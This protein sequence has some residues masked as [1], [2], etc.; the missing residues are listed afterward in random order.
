MYILADGKKHF[1]LADEKYQQSKKNL[2]DETIIFTDK[3]ESLQKEFESLK[4]G[5]LMLSENLELK[6]L[7]PFFGFQ[8]HFLCKF[9]GN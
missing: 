9:D 6:I 2:E 8:I 7:S 4:A 5:N 1:A 3:F